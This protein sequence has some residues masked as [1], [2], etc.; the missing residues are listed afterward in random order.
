MSQQAADKT[1]SLLAILKLL[2]LSR[3]KFHLHGNCINA[4]IFYFFINNF[5]F[6]DLFTLIFNCIAYKWNSL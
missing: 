4:E 5:V 2:D 3:L 6:V 1:S